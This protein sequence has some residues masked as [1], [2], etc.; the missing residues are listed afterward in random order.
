MYQKRSILLGSSILVAANFL[1]KLTPDVRKNVFRC[2]LQ[3]AINSLEGKDIPEGALDSVQGQDISLSQLYESYAGIHNLIQSF[4]SLPQGSVNSDHLKE[5]LKEVK[6]PDECQTDLIN[7]LYGPKRLALDE[8]NCQDSFY[9][10]LEKLRWR[11]DITISSSVLS[12]V[13]EP[14]ILFEMTLSN[15][16]KKTFEVSISKFHQIRYSVASILKEMGLMEKKKL[17]KTNV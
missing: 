6:F 1:S 7:I 3:L 12:R 14:S 17:F 16:E 10:K 4:I 2:M 5:G 9:L 15:G 13:L 11:V 8:K